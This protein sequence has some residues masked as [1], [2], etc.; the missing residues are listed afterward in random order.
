MREGSSV[1]CT[2]WDHLDKT[3]TWLQWYL[4]T[5]HSVSVPLTAKLFPFHVC[6]CVSID[7]QCSAWWSAVRQE[8]DATVI[9]HR[10]HNTVKPT[11]A[12]SRWNTADTDCWLRA[13]SRDELTAKMSLISETLWH[14]FFERLFWLSTG[15][16]SRLIRFQ[17]AFKKLFIRARGDV[18]KMPYVWPKTP[19]YS[20]IFGKL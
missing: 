14:T 7:G 13:G 3:C 18:L 9:N 8:S 10:G 16:I 4:T 6:V 20:K 5:R 15:S 2:A 11:G 17:K 12:A 19:R 1:A